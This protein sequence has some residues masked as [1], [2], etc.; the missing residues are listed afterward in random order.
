[1]VID[2]LGFDLLPPSE[3]PEAGTYAAAGFLLALAGWSYRRRSRV[4]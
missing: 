2:A 1:M 4:A 3:I